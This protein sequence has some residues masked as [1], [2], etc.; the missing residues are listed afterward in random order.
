MKI[1][2]SKCAKYRFPDISYSAVCYTGIFKDNWYCR[3]EEEVYCE[4]R[5]KHNDCRA[6][7]PNL[8]QR[9]KNFFKGK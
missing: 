7:V 8:F 4:V 3:Y 9:I 5:N 6:Y 1:Y 2:C